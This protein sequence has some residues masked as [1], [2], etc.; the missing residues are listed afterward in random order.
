MQIIKKSLIV[1]VF[2]VGTLVVSQ[3]THSYLQDKFND[4]KTKIQCSVL[5][6]PSNSQMIKCFVSSLL[7][8]TKDISNAF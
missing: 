7:T 8:T 5:V 6:K 1:I 2:V 3:N 4:S